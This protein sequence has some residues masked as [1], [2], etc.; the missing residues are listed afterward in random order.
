V[1]STRRRPLPRV[2][3]EILFCSAHGGPSFS[4]LLL[5]MIFSLP[6]SPPA[7]PFRLRAGGKSV[8]FP[9][10]YD[11]FFPFFPSGENHTFLLPP[12]KTSLL[13]RS[14]GAHGAFPMNT[15]ILPFSFSIAPAFFL[16]GIHRNTGISLSFFPER[17]FFLLHHREGIRVVLF[18][19]PP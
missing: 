7:P 15:L 13:H 17:S 4:S 16:L 3:K 10:P 12:P 2:V 9:A 1:F 11:S 5:A 18:F 19:P 8:F 6:E 14:R